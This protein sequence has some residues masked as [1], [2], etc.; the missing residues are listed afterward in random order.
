MLVELEFKNVGFCGGRQIGEPGDWEQGESG[1]THIEQ[2][3]I[4]CRKTK[5]KLITYQL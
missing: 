4:E 3:S 5:T 2:F 1:S